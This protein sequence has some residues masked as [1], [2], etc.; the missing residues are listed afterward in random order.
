MPQLFDRETS[1]PITPPSLEDAHAGLVSGKYALDADAGPVTLR[2]ANGKTYKADPNKVAEAL[3]T[4]KFSL[5]SPED[6]LKH[7][8]AQEESAKG[9]VGS[10]EEAGK[11]AANQLFLGIPGAIADE[12]MSP[13]QAA[14]REAVEQYHSAART[15]GGVAGFGAS[16]LFG[17]EIFK[18]AE[19]AGQAIEHG[20]IPAAEV[21]DAALHTRMAAKAA[22]YATQGV[23]MSSPQ[24]LIQA[25]AGDPK[26]AAETLL[27]GIGAG[28]VLGGGGE[29]LSSGAGAAT[30]AIG[31][32]L[33]TTLKDPKVASWLDNWANERTLKAFGAERSQLNKL[34]KERMADLANFAHDEGLLRVGDSRQGIGDLV[35]KAKG[36]WGGEIGSTIDS[37]DGLLK[38]GEGA[39]I[40]PKPPPEIMDAAL[41]PGQLGD[42]IR[43][44]LDGPE[45]R[46]P[47]NAD[48]A[49]A[50]EL[51][52]ASAD[53]LPSQEINGQRVVSFEAAQKFVSDLRK[54]WVGSVSKSMNDGG[55]KG[56]ETVTALD[57]MKANAY[58]VA[59]DAVHTA[60]DKVAVASGEP[61]IVGALAKAKQNYSKLAELEKFASTLDRVQAGNRM[62]GLT[63][64]IHMGQGPMSAAT[65]G[66]GAALGSL[67]GPG[68]AIVGQ[69][70]GRVPGMALDFMAK[71]WM[72]DKGLVA[73]SALAKKAAREGPEVFSAVMASEGAKRLEATMTGVRDAIKQM[74]VRGISDTTPGGGSDHMRHLLG[75]TQ[76][77]TGDQAYTKLGSR[78]TAL[79]ANPE[80]LTAATAGASA[81]FAA[82]SPQLGAAYQQQLTQ[83]I[84][85]LHAALPKNSTPAA[86]F[87][88]DDWTPSATDK[89]AFHDKAEIVANPMRAMVHMQRGTLSDA[90]I[91]ALQN[92]YPSILSTMQQEILGF[93]AK[94]PDVKLPLAERRSVAKILGSPLDTISQS[95]VPLQAT[96]QTGG[97]GQPAQP[98]GMKAPKGKLKNMPSAASAFT[99]SQGPASTGA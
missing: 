11:S 82:G 81:P 53:A 91:D 44:A 51:V 8:V 68:G 89:L 88:P 93:S 1:Q 45:L 94:H 41:K 69:Q 31:E 23:L 18:G 79:A 3:A 19:L 4:K 72:E 66:L 62:V 55:V 32:K 25:A 13:E 67:A 24:S 42:S 21:A 14:K 27:W 9:V 29:L 61:K 46:M 58:Q 63:D 36:K 34:S 98:P 78:L 43:Q 92:V 90:H 30:D 10:L 17:G 39:A 49:K 48:Q 74:A 56:L 84:Q 2:G 38:R 59:R 65:Q 20:I 96:Y 54:K 77:L 5:L 86:P 71:K 40:G 76:G 35:E 26:K 99:G 80:A 75:S 60:A 52:A 7:Q 57:A 64:M 97:A 37:L 73:I 47:M 33:S 50:L 6:E 95:L 15:I 22:N 85:Y 87:E 70:L 28:A 83:A 12:S 16:A